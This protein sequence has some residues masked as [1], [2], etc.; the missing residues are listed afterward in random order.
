MRDDRETQPELEVFTPAADVAVVVLFGEH[1]LTT[2]DTLR[3]TLE[4]AIE[5]YRVIVT[6]LSDVLYV[7]SSTLAELLRADRTA[8]RAGKQ[9]RIQ[10]GAE[11]I[12]RRVLEIS[13]LLKVLDVYAT[14][15][16]AIEG[17][18]IK[19]PDRLL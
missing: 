19:P 1:D 17:L 9:F 10:L 13:G 6:D 5:T 4:S 2:K 12:V 15:E 7:D 18:P 14:R 16:D 8:R 3:D 11:P